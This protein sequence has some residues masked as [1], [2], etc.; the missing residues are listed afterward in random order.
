MS[1]GPPRPCRSPPVPGWPA[2]WPGSGSPAGARAAAPRP[3]APRR[4]ARSRSRPPRSSPALVGSLIPKEKEAAMRHRRS[5]RMR[6]PLAPYAAGFRAELASRGYAAVSV[7]HRAAQ[8]SRSAGGWTPNGWS[9]SMRTSL[10][11]ATLPPGW[12]LPWGPRDPAIATI[13]DR[14]RVRLASHR[15][16]AAPNAQP[17]SIRPRHSSA[18]LTWQNDFECHPG[19][20]VRPAKASRPH[21]RQ[22]SASIP[23]IRHQLYCCNSAASA[24]KVQADCLAGLTQPDCRLCAAGRATASTAATAAAST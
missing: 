12:R 17:G 22:S 2:S 13:R 5:G 16:H 9:R 20:A 4:T 15:G 10:S 24:L 14:S 18:E 19:S 3:T 1:A 23:E 11:A 8:F 6:G 21:A 7:E